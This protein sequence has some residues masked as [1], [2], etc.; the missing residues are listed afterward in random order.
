MHPD[1][2]ARLCHDENFLRR[3]VEAVGEQDRFVDESNIREIHVRLEMS[4][5]ERA[6]ENLPTKQDY[7]LRE[8]I[9]DLFPK[10]KQTP[11]FSSNV[12]P[13]QLYRGMTPSEARRELARRGLE[14]ADADE[15]IAFAPFFYDRGE[16]WT[17]SWQ[18]ES[19]LIST[20]A[21]L[22]FGIG[23]EGDTMLKKEGATSFLCLGRNIP[24]DKMLLLHEVA[25]R[26]TIS[27]RTLFLV[28]KKYLE[29]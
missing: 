27:A 25:S 26:K 15:M 21:V 11:F 12:F 10:R 22:P 8:D 20:G 18:P 4:R 29:K 3:V 7:I 5:F 2:W 17:R 1:V 28:K 13:I 9:L 23:W 6:K 19:T 16:S 14:G 24:G